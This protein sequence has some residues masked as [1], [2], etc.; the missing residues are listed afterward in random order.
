MIS[1]LEKDFNKIDKIA[2]KHKC[3][4][5]FPPIGNRKQNVF[6][7]VPVSI[8][9]GGFNKL[10]NDLRKS[11]LEYYPLVVNKK[12]FIEIKMG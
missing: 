4:L 2:Q 8:K 3:E 10:L 7:Y 9:T 1:K 6:I 12:F 11:K 5:L